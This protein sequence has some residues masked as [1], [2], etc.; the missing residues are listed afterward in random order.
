VRQ[1]DEN[2][3]SKERVIARDLEGF[4]GVR[5]RVKRAVEAL[6]R[7]VSLADALKQMA[8]FH[9]SKRTS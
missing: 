4:A 1:V 5:G 9:A 7:K 2:L 3:Y 8:R 6:P